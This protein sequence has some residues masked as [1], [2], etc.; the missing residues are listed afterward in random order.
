MLA[1]MAHLARDYSGES[2][3]IQHRS[4]NVHLIPLVR[5]AES[6]CPSLRTMREILEEDLKVMST[7][8]HVR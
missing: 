2:L 3:K 1:F 8:L 7:L 5:S 6:V 4:L